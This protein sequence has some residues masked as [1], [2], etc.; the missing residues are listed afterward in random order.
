MARILLI[1]NGRVTCFHMQPGKTITTEV[2]IRKTFLLIVQP[3]RQ[4]RCHSRSKHFQS[5]NKPLISTVHDCLNETPV[6]YYS[7]STQVSQ[8]HDSSNRSNIM[9]YARVLRGVVLHFGL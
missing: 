9:I 8:T 7:L 4:N 5:C 1:L 2:F 6:D 3:G